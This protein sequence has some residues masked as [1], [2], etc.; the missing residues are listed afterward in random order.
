MYICLSP[1]EK[2]CIKINISS[3]FSIRSKK[4]KKKK[5]KKSKKA[6]SGSSSEESGGEEG[7]EEDED[8]GLVWVEKTCMDEN[9]VGPEAP[10]AQMS[11]DDKPLEWVHIR[12]L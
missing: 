10:L 9:L 8:G 2:G 6:S 7:E 11:Q 4:S 3:L 1:T 12:D 5:V